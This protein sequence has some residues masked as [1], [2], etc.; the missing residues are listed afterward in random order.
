MTV[1]QLVPVRGRSIGPALATV[2]SATLTRR[3]EGAYVDVAMSAVRPLVRALAFA[4]I[5]A[6]CCEPDLAPAPALL[7]AR[8]LDLAPLAPGLVDVDVV[9]IE[10][11]PLG[12]ATREVLVRR[13][14]G[15]L[16]PAPPAR[17]RCHLL[18]RGDQ[19]LFAWGRRAWGTRQALRSA[20]ARRSLRPIV[21]DREA[22][23][24]SDL[25]G[26]ISS[27]ADDLAHWLFG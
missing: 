1:L 14:G 19:V 3:S 27:D 23:A 9:R 18:L 6:Q 17:A 16:P 10:R 24:R 21:F 25:A 4:G 22:L 26:R 15:L 2:G 8:G 13:L 7:P 12:T 5:D 20:R 11:I